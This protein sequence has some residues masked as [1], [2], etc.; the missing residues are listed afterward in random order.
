MST[1]K[2]HLISIRSN[3]NFSI[4]YTNLTLKTQIELIIL[5]QEPVYD[6][7]KKR[8]IVK[9]AK[10]GEFRFFTSLEGINDMIG[11]LQALA[12]QLQTFEQM[13]VGMNK[14]IENA[15]QKQEQK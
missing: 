9:S 2:K 15:K 12:I 13:S 4:D 3:T 11:E 14:I 6:V 7:N 8:E 1:T 10:L 5:C